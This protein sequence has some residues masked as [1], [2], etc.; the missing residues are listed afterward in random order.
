MPKRIAVIAVGVAALG[1]PAAA[2]GIPSDAPAHYVPYDQ[3]ASYETH[4]LDVRRQFVKR[5]GLDEA[6]RN[7]VRDGYRANDG[8][9]HPA[10][11]DRIVASTRTMDASLHPPTTAP[12]TSTSTTASSATTGYAGGAAS[13]SST[14]QCESGGSYTAVNPAGYYGAYQFD[15]QTW[16]AYAPSGYQGVNPASAPPAVQDQAAASVPYDAWPNC[17]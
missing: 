3:N 4:Y 16:D 6:G 10:G 11:R 8:G 5:F 13:S 9:V 2:Q 1:A 17:G 7:I 14:A 12:D 15:Q